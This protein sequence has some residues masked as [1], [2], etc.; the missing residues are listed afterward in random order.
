MSAMPTPPESPTS[1]LSG[2]SRMLIQML[3]EDWSGP[4]GQALNGDCLNILRSGINLLST[5]V[6]HAVTTN[7]VHGMT[8]ESLGEGDGDVDLV[9]L[10]IRLT[11][12][13]V[14]DVCAELKA[15]LP[16]R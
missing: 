6:D 7:A 11:K 15:N 10:A 8:M 16:N 12:R 1:L 14:K 4:Y 13:M 9:E 5:M 3:T 2:D